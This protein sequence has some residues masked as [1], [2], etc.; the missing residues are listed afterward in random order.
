MYIRR[1]KCRAINSKIGINKKC[2]HAPI[3][4]GNKLFTSVQIKNVK[5]LK[6]VVDKTVVCRYNNFC[7]AKDKNN[8]ERYRSGHNEAVLKTVC[9]RGRVGSNPT[10]SASHIC[11]N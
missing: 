11:E 2:P 9:P 10:L 8:S 4:S 5:K 3:Q 6:N 7:S 1:G